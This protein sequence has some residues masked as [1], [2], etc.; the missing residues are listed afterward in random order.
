MGWQDAHMYEFSS[1]VGNNEETLEIVCDEEIFDE[2]Q[3]RK[4]NYLERIEAGETLH[5]FDLRWYD[6]AKQKQMKKAWTYKLT[7]YFKNPGDTITYRYD[8][9]DDWHHTITLESIVEGYPVGYPMLLE[10]EGNCPPEDV[11]GSGG[12]DY[13]LEAWNHPEHPEH[14]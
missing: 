1:E 12:F 10:A 6:N 5:K 3:W 14:E 13:F 9:G 7:S 11:G 2:F 4:E 8:F